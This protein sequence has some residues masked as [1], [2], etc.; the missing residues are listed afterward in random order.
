MWQVVPWQWH[1]FR[2]TDLPA[3]PKPPGYAEMG[4]KFCGLGE[5]F[6][7]VYLLSKGPNSF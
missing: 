6:G 7:V 3:V 4:G 2:G 5:G 1:I